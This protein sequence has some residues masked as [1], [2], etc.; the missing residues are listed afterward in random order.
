MGKWHLT[1]LTFVCT[2]D[3]KDSDG[4]GLHLLTACSVRVTAERAAPHLILTVTLWASQ[5]L[6]FVILVLQMR[7]RTAE[8]DW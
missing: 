1:P 3:R 8:R 7:K 5:V 2:W 6:L 4:N